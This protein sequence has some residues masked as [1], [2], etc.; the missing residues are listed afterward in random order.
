V[1]LVSILL[2][3]A[4][5]RPDAVAIAD[6][7][8][9]AAQATFAEL[10]AAAAGVAGGLVRRGVAPGDRVVIV[11][12]NDVDFVRAYLGALWAGGVAVPLNPLAPAAELEA[13]VA[14]VEPTVVV[15]AGRGASVLARAEPVGSV[16]DGEPLAAEVER[17]DS[18]LAV[19]L[20]TSGT[21][22]AP[23]AAM[24]THG[25]LE[26]NI[27]QVQGQP[28]LRVGA[29]DVGLA[30]LPFFHVFGLN[31]ALGV[32]LAAGMRSILMDPFD[33]ARA[34]EAVRDHGIT[35][36]AGVPA[37]FAAILELDEAVAPAGCLRSLRLAVSGAAPLP[38]EVVDG[39]AARFG[40]RLAEGYGLTEAAP[41]VCTNAAD[42]ESP[43]GS[44]GPPLPGVEVRLV[45]GDGHDVVV[46]DPG[47]LWVRG[48]NVFPGYWR[49]PDATARV[50]VD[51]WLRTGDVGV[52]DEDGELRLVDRIKDLVIVSGF[53]VFPAE[54]EDVLLDHPAV[55][56]AAVVGEPHPRTGEALV[57]WVVPAPGTAPTAAELR[58]FA[59]G[60]LARY[61][62]PARVEL[63]EML[64]RNLSGKVLRREL[65]A[66]TR[67]PE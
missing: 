59:T 23:R 39:F 65:R 4:S 16:A 38:P 28:G 10:E 44:I 42:A 37:M 25:N 53:N 67:N 22:G 54:V 46:G 50:L 43:R 64:P 14:D 11:E 6:A 1:N 52:A 17:D 21:A 62:V 51:G 58:E 45:G 57:A 32:A 29:D 13:E 24:L 27:G 2:A 8:D 41:I 31:V 66:A 49:D 3:A 19:L 26:A 61:K 60:R 30:T 7:A 48:P 20:F 35:I 63:V 36:L 18:D 56:E 47:E 12:G 15:G 33:A 55:A 40:V 5:D 9:P 34:V